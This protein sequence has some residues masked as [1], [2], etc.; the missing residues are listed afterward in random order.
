VARAAAAL[1][2]LLG[3]PARDVN[4]MRQAA[5]LHDIGKLGISD[6]I[7]L[8]PGKLTAE[9]FDTMRLHAALGA[10]IL[11]GSRSDVLQL[12]ERIA[13]THHEWW[14]G[15]GYPGKLGGD[16][17]PQCGRIVALADVFD[18]L[19]HERPYKEAWSVDRAVEEV[20]RLRGLQ[21]D[22]DVVDAFDELDADELAGSPPRQADDVDVAA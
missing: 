19:T 3:L 15:S 6:T 5:P 8:K 7:L 13:L 2:R 18:A 4:L 20:H 16:D 12:A 11:S 1:T 22:P 9:E 17:I 14:D 21:F 10:E